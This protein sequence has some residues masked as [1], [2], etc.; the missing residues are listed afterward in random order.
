[1]K[2]SKN[3]SKPDKAAPKAESAFAEQAQKAIRSAQRVAAREN[4][5]FGLRLIVEEKR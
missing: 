1:M 4:A 5:R 3:K 2:S